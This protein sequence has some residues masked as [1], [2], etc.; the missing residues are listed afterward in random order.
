MLFSSK[1][2]HLLEGLA[3]VLLD[4]D[5]AIRII[6]RTEKD[7]DVVPNL[8]K[9]FSITEEQANFIAEIKL[10]NLNKDYILNKTKSIEQLTEDLK[11][12]DRQLR[13]EKEIDKIIVKTLREIQKKYGIPR[14]TE[15]VTDYEDVRTPVVEEKADYPVKVYVT[16]EGYVKKLAL[17]SIKNDPEIK[18]KEGDA[19]V[20]VYDSFN[21]KELLVFTDRQAVYK[22][23][24]SD[25]KDSKPSDIADYINN[26]C[27][28]ESGESIIKACTSDAGENVIIG[29]ENGKVAKFPLSAYET[30]QNRKKL[31]NAI[32][33][34]SKPLRICI[35]REDEDFAI[36][37][38]TGKLLVFS[39]EKVPL[40]TTKTTQ[41]VQVIRLAKGQTAVS[42]GRVKEF[43]LRKKEDYR[44]ANIP[45]AG[46]AHAN[47]QLS[48]F[49]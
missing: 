31:V 33:D 20:A 15:I 16:K 34:A 49:D 41:G 1:E 32:S 6:R 39:S 29:F 11:T 27:E 3:K 38:S 47:V 35:I 43:R 37:S 40:K 26:I 42:F 22:V 28:I 24:L 44:S 4:I 18:F 14:K 5:K 21:S 9:G 17:T 30:K 2:L 45:A 12:I 25:L 48:L 19:V 13:S 8:M 23:Q 7:E 10:R 36:Q 46:K